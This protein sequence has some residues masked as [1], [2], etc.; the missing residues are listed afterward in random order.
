LFVGDQNIV[1]AT[2]K[3]IDEVK[4]GVSEDIEQDGKKI[5][6]VELYLRWL[7]GFNFI[8]TALEVSLIIFLRLMR[9]DLIPHRTF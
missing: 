5:L 1:Y 8:I 3:I 6:E 2:Q 7:E 4:R 9:P